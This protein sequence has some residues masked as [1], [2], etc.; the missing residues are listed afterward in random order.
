MN[1]RDRILARIRA[2]QR[3]PGAADAVEEETVRAYLS[4]HAPGPRPPTAGDPVAL[5]RARALALAS[6]LAEIDRLADVPR[7]VADYLSGNGLPLVAAC[8]PQWAL[9]DWSHAGVRVTG[10]AARA[11]DLVGITGAFCGI[12]ETGTLML[13]SGSDTPAT[14]SLLPETHV[15]ILH[16]ERIVADME[17]AWEH[18]RREHGAMPRAINFVSGPSRTADIEQTVTLGAHGPYRVHIVL[19]HEAMRSL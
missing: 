17:E 4:G 15:A 7:A 16:A 8:W 6:T 11:D 18:L 5:F 10:G 3:R 9:L 12:A 1:A 2:A 14:V 13:V 19:V